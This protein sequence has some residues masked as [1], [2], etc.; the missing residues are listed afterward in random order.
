MTRLTVH[1]EEP[2]FTERDQKNVGTKENPI[3]Q[4]KK[5]KCIKNTL[6]FRNVSMDEAKGI[7]HNVRNNYGITKWKE[8]KRKGQEMIYI[9]N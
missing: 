9:V 4:P 3:M 6:S 7:L 5:K 8:G 2:I 1:L